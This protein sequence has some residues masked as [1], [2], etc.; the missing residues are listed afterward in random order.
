MTI[1]QLLVVSEYL[2]LLSQDQIAV[3]LE[4]G[5]PSY[6]KPRENLIARSE[7]PATPPGVPRQCKR[8]L[9][10]ICT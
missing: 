4:A 7:L 10:R 2:S 1:R 5:W 9:M 8:N 6:A 3:E